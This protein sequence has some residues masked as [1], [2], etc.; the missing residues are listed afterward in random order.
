MFVFL[1]FDFTLLESSSKI[2][3]TLEDVVL[4][5]VV[6]VTTASQVPLQQL[7][8]QPS[9]LLVEMGFHPD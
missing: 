7:L 3:P 1:R 4:R 5:C 2:H 9:I 6:S 8:I